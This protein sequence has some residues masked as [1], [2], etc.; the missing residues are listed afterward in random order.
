TAAPER[1]GQIREI[2]KIWWPELLSVLLGFLSF[3]GKYITAYASLPL[4]TLILIKPTQ[5]IIV[6]LSKFNEQSLPDWPYNITLN[7]FLA[8]VSTC[9]RDTCMFPVSVAISQAQ[10]SWFLKARPL[11]DFHLR[12][13]ASRSPWG[14]LVLLWRAPVFRHPLALGAILTVIGVLTTP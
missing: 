12:D 1:S 11:Y 3:I 6:V 8:I 14:S 9:A 10:W 4:G 5:G 2:W 13:Q 7:T